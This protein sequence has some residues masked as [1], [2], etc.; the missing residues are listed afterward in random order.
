MGQAEN[1]PKI[2]HVVLLTS[3]RFS[4][5]FFRLV[6]ARELGPKQFGEY[7]LSLAL[8][9][10]LAV[11]SGSG[12]AVYL[13]REAAKDARVGW[14]LG[15]QLT[16]LRLACVVLLGGAGLGVLWMLGY[17]RTMLVA[18]AWLSLSLAP[19]L[20]TEVVQGVLRGIGR[21]V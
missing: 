19:R 2:S 11:A 3:A 20:L 10:M 5:G 17:S 12:H 4:R 8:V 18:G 14:G 21:Y 9:E 16:W 1:T 15:S 6:V 7:S 13:T